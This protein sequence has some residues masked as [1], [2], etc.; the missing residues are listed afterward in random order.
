MRILIKEEAK[1][2]QEKQITTVNTRNDK[3]IKVVK[4]GPIKARESFE[5]RNDNKNHGTLISGNKPKP[6]GGHQKIINT[7]K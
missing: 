7:E 5:K 2:I 4:K 6:D 1:K 3:E